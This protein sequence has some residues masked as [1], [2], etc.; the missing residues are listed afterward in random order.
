V[1]EDF[2]K[3]DGLGSLSQA[4][5]KKS[6]KSARR[7]LIVIGIL[8]LLANGVMFMLAEKM[9]DDQI[10]KERKQ[11]GPGMVFDQQKI[12]EIR[13][14]QIKIQKLVSGGFVAV[15]IIFIM[16]G[17]MVYKA[18]VVCTVLG[19]VLYLAGWFIPIV[20]LFL[21]DEKEDASKALLSGIIIKIIIIVALIKAIQSAIAYQNEEATLARE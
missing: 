18:P 17:I 6:L 20:L 4:A 1:P 7:I 8:S 2:D 16:L 13:D 12:K 3:P 21:G 14:S 9:V 10:E 15:S 11:L 19:L 5:R